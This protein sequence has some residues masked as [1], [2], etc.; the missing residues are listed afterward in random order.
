MIKRYY[1][2][3]EKYLEA[4]KVLVIFGARQV[5]KTTLLKN[6]LNSTKYKYKFDSGD[7]IKVQEALSSQDFSRIFDYCEG[8]EL[9][10]IDEAQRI[11]NIGMGLKII[12]DNIPKIK[13]IV[14][15][16]SSFELSGQVG[17]PLTGRKRTLD[18]Y[19]IAQLE[20]HDKQYKN[21]S[22]HEL[23]E[24]LSE[25]LVFGSYPAVLNQDDKEQKIIALNEIT[26]SYL[27]KDIFELEKVKNSKIII[28]L[29]RLIAFQLGS[30]VSYH[31]L[32][33]QLGIDYK[34]VARYLD[35]MEQSFILFN[36]RGFSRNLRKEIH[37]KSKYYFYDLGIRN[38]IISN[39]N[40]L[41]LRNDI[42]QLW[43]NFLI[44]ERLKK[45]RY[46]GIFANNYFWRTWEGKEIDF[47]E[48][49]EGKLFAYEFKWQAKQSKIPKDFVAQY[50]EHE[51][52]EINQE[53]YLDFVL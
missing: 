18:M 14:T 47:I 7:S 29:L 23:R 46:T 17:E 12:V 24:N 42:G 35:L 21:F 22:R 44:I 32:A 50:P 41:N 4:N 9:I 31:E 25:F 11:P 39:F 40:N 20:L 34:T 36:L 26:N 19:P 45:Q 38:S 30:E 43:E 37:K 13:V 16:S 3:L 48:E 51:F 28:D 52:K 49:R 8:Y 53:N 10:V 27:F 33:T 2:N 15:G 1:Q 5:G 6:F